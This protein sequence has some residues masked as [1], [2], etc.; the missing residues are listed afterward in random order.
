LIQAARTQVLDWKRQSPLQ[1]TLLPEPS[2]KTTETIGVAASRVG[3][4]YGLDWTTVVVIPGTDFTERITDSFNRGL[5]IAVAA[6]FLALTFGMWLLNRLL[7][8]IRALNEAVVRIGR[9]E[10]IP[11]L[12][13]N[14]N[15]E[16]GQ[17]ARSF[18]EMGH[19][20]RTDK[21]TGAYNR[22]YLF[23]QFRLIREFERKQGRGSHPFALMFID[24]DDF[25]EINDRHG[26]DRGDAVLI[27][28]AA[29]L[30]SGVRASDVVVRYGGDEFVILL[31]DMATAEDLH[32]AE[33]KIRAIVEA[34]MALGLETIR[35]GI[36]IGWSLY[37]TEG[38]DID[39]LIKTADT[40]MFEAKRSRK[41][42]SG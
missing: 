17:L 4:R 2:D 36:S 14:R 42:E 38:Q 27:E 11:Q 34:P 12:H 5:V 8:D 1:E 16:I 13:I 40:R 25:K 31:N 28:I 21:L 32:A 9:G 19:S 24:L 7:S 15:D 3:L 35:P 37:P 33:E 30:K 26:H 18:H 6:V 29:R 41:G 10:S 23:S 22:N 20:L 39:A